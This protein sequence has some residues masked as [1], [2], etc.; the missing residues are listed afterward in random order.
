[1]I[2]EPPGGW[3][4]F[5]PMRQHGGNRETPPGMSLEEAV[6]CTVRFPDFVGWGKE[7]FAATVAYKDRHGVI[8]YIKE[9]QGHHGHVSHQ[10]E[11]LQMLNSEGFE[12]TNNYLLT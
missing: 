1:M 12:A 4:V 10:D 11:M 9:Q 2:A 3:I 7:Y 6:F 5:N 8:E